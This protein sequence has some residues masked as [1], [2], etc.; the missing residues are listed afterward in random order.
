MQNQMYKVQIVVFLLFFSFNLIICKQTK[1]IIHCQLA[2]DKYSTLKNYKQPTLKDNISFIAQPSS[3]SNQFTNNASLLTYTNFLQS[4]IFDDYFCNQRYFLSSK[5][6]NKLLKSKYNEIISKLLSQNQLSN[7]GIVELWLL[8]KAGCY[9]KSKI[10]MYQNELI[11]KLNEREKFLKT[12]EKHLSDNQQEELERN[13]GIYNNK[14]LISEY[15]SQYKNSRQQALNKTE[16]ENYKSY[17]KIQE[18][19]FK[20]IGFCKA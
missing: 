7:Y 19:D 1:T 15:K 11:E 4:I 5:Q 9:K 10:E 12:R 3:N 8:Y 14:L 18:L 6:I 20:T 16:K 13:K 2:D 17:E